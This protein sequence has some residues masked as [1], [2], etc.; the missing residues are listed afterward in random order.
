[1]GKIIVIDGVDGSG[2]GTQCKLL[3]ERL[4]R[5]NYALYSCSFPRYEDEASIFVRRYLNGDYGKNPS[6]VSAYQASYFYALDR[7]NFFKTNKE[8]IE[9]IADPNVIMVSDRYTTSNLIHQ[10]TKISDKQEQAK[11]NE[12]LWKQ[13][14]EILGIPKPDMVIIPVLEPEANMELVRKRNIAA[15]AT[16]NK[17]STD[18]H[19]TDM[20]YLRKTIESSRVVVEQMS[21]D[22]IDCMNKDGGIRTPEDIHEEIYKRV[23]KKVL[24]KVRKS[25]N[26]S[27]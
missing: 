22:V 26:S 13:E 12:W 17:M 6:D 4:E 20:E 23:E 8:A 14:Y 21:F 15:R 16:E 18:I 9:A 1:M 19:E 5:E 3:K 25:H 11:F 10:G 2:K 27:Y 7:F 24:R